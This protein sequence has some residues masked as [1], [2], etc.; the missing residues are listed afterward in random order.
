M[1][2]FLTP[3]IFPGISPDPVRCP[4]PRN[5]TSPS[6]GASLHIVVDVSGQRQSPFCLLRVGSLC[7]HWRYVNRVNFYAEISSVDPYDLSGF[8]V[9][10]LVLFLK[11]F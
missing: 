6:P 5:E 10:R 3:P 7:C 4:C 1:T 9:N 2:P 8:Y 11:L